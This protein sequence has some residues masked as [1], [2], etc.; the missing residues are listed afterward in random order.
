MA[1]DAKAN[2]SN[3]FPPAKTKQKTY[4]VAFISIAAVI[5]FS[6]FLIWPIAQDI[7]KYSEEL[8]VQKK[9][10][11]VSI[12]E[13]Q[14]TQDDRKFYEN[15][16]EALGKVNA[17]FVNADI[18]IDLIK[19]LEDNAASVN[20]AISIA[21][22]II[23]DK[24]EKQWPALAFHLSIQGSFSNLLKFVAKMESGP[25]LIDIVSLDIKG[26]IEEKKIAGG[27]S[28]GDVSAII[29]IKALTKK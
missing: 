1:S 11:S 4:I 6:V 16:K 21:P 26:L 3:S 10:F 13:A 25:Y 8:A 9:N 29:V 27:V 28:S 22:G 18:P 14:S 23:D 2:S 17:L 15:G 5:S 24:E 19:F 20:L 7:K 12:E